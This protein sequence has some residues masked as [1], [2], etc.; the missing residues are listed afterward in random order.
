[1][2]A[3]LECK[4]YQSTPGVGLGRTFVGLVSDCAN[5]RLKGFVSN[6]PSEKLGQYFSKTSRP[7]PFLGLI[8]TDTQ[9]EERFIHNI[10]QMLRKW[11]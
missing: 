4:F 8:P 6:L 5:L 7:E 10:E 9:S 2:I 1:M 11:A 3:A